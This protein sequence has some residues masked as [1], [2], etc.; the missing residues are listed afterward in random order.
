MEK[1][2]VQSLV[3]S[4]RVPPTRLH[5]DEQGTAASVTASLLEDAL[6]EQDAATATAVEQQAQIGDL[7][8]VVFLFVFFFCVIVRLAGWLIAW[9]LAQGIYLGDEIVASMTA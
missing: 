6:R 1:D 2:T 3:M 4:G 7:W 8:C 9:T 5:T